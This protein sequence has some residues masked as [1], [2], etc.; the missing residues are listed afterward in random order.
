[1][2]NITIGGLS[3]DEFLK[4]LEPMPTKGRT[5]FAPELEVQLDDPAML[6]DRPETHYPEQ[7]PAK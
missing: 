1:M 3:K 6:G 2:A 5:H 7:P 4:S